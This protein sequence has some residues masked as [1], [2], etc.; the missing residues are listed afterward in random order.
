MEADM[1]DDACAR[2]GFGHDTQL[3]GLPLPA[4]AT[5]QRFIG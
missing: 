5:E 3:L 4:I 1:G 2:T